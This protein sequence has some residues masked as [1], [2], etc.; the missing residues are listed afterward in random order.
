MVSVLSIARKELATFFAAPIA[1]IFFGVFLA[2][3]LF[4]FFW[5]ETFFARNI[6]DVR[7]LFEWMPILLIFLV[8]ALTMRMWSEERR[9]GTLEFLFTTPVSPLHFVLGKFLACF[10]LVG[11]AVG[12][13]LPVA[14]SVSLIG[15]LDWGPVF[16]AYLAILFLA[17]AYIAIGLFV[18]SLSDNQIVS[19]VISVAICCF[20][21][22]LGSDTLAVLFGNQT[23]EFLKLLGSGSRFESITRGVIDFRDLYYYFSIF[24]VFV[25]LNSYALEQ[26]RWSKIGHRIS[27]RRWRFVTVLVAANFLVA[28]FWLHQIGW[29]RVDITQGN[30]YSLSDATR[31]Y[32]KHLREPLLIRGYF[33]SQT[34]PLLAPLVPRLRDLIQEYGVA[35]SGG[36]RVEF[37]DPL[38]NPELEKEAGQKYAIKP[39]A[40]QTASKYQAAVV[41]SYFDILIQYGDQYETLGF[42]DLIEVKSNAG[43]ELDVKL[44]NPEYDITRAIK[45]VLYSYQGSG[46][47][48]ANLSHQVAFKGYIS[49]KEKLPKSLID[50]RESIQEVLEE[51]KSAANGNFSFSIADP[52][53][54]GKTVVKEIKDKYGFRP[55]RA[56]LFDPTSFWFYMI[57]EG[58]GRVIQVPLPEELE[59]SGFKRGV[60]AALKRFST[61]FLKTVAFHSPEDTSAGPNY[62]YNMHSAQFQQVQNSLQENHVVKRSDLKKGYVPQEADLLIMA[63]PKEIDDK[64]LFAMDQF[65]MKGGTV[66]LATSPFNLSLEGSIKASRHKSNIESWLQHHG[67]KIDDTMVLDPQNSAFPIPVTRNLGGFNVQELRL[68]EY[69]YFVDIREAGLNSDNMMTSSLTQLTLH[70]PSPIILDEKKQKDRKIT[71]LLES[72]KGSWT[73]DSLEMQPDFQRY[74]KLGFP[75]EKKRKSFLLAAAIEGRFNSFYKDKPSPLLKQEKNNQKTKNTSTQK[76]NS[77]KKEELAKDDMVDKKYENKTQKAAITNIIDKSAA[78][79]R[80]I[81]FASNMFIEDRVLELAAGINQKQYL[82]TIQLVENAIDMSLEDGGLLAIRS[83]GNFSRTLQSLNKTT[84]LIFE[85]V[86]YGVAFLGLILVYTFYRRVRNNKSKHYRVIL[87]PKGV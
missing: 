9:A 85:Y 46:D 62:R 22:L 72:S 66:I 10:A 40:F 69:P 64:Q 86:N 19:L 45:K 39:V 56:G 63:A 74:G 8:S 71:R 49:G 68:V 37:I 16:G 78:S 77:V 82:N 55:M 28:N 51:F 44:R 48:F 84:K 7:P 27:H 20:F 75:T 18:S 59:K 12:L 14:F 5:V 53:E 2:V 29:A 36:I 61:G 54:G 50:F 32:L 42:R 31:S 21:Y 11:I 1:F 35:G 43:L 33:S 24:A 15:S 38:E 87:N 13:T 76:E 25:V 70:W 58:D 80:I 30:I 73:S 26:L 17:S 67:I 34:H 23:S 3:T 4:V 52:D 79:A 83:R 60:E 6:A 47:L 57:M 65:L 81:L 41:N